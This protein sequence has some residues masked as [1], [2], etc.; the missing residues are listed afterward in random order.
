[1]VLLTALICLAHMYAAI[2]INKSLCVYDYDIGELLLLFPLS[3]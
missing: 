1:M 3:N 2:V